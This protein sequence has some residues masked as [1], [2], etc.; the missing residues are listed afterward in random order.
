MI[1]HNNNVAPMLTINDVSRALNL[2]VNTVRRWS[3]QGILKSYR[4]GFR[5]DHRFEREEITRF[6]KQSNRNR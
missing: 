1:K 4:I 5:G 2:H 6:L 3:N